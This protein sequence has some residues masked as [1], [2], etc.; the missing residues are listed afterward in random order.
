MKNTVTSASSRRNSTLGF[1]LKW[2]VEATENPREDF[3]PVLPGGTKF[4]AKLFQRL[5]A[6]QFKVMREIFAI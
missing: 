3:F 1:F 2:E 4:S 6:N 5:N